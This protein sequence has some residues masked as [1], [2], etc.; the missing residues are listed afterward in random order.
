VT[1]DL[2]RRWY[3]SDRTLGPAAEAAFL[4]S[5]GMGPDYTFQ[6]VEVVDSDLRRMSALVRQYADLQLGGTDA[7]VAA[8]CEPLGHSSSIRHDRAPRCR[9]RG[10]LA[11]SHQT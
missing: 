7:L 9:L 8:I 11:A 1:R 10:L 5:V 4:D 2:A 6:L 3:L